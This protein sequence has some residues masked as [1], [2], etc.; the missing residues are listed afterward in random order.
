MQKLH[1]SATLPAP[2]GIQREN[3]TISY[4]KYGSG[5]I[6]LTALG[7]YILTTSGI[8]EG[9][10]RRTTEYKAAYNK[11][12]MDMLHA[13]ESDNRRYTAIHR[14]MPKVSD[15]C[16]YQKEL[17]SLAPQKYKRAQFA[18]L[19]PTKDSVE[20]DL[21]H[22]VQ[23]LNFD[24]TKPEKVSEKD[25]I[26]KN[27]NSLTERRSQSWIEAK[28][29]FEQIEEVRA[30]R[31]NAR[32]LAEY[33]AIYNKKQ[34][35]IDGTESAVK[36]VLSSL[37]TAIT[38][39]YNIGITCE[40]KRTA[41]QLNAEIIFEDGVN[42]PS[43][44]ATILASGKISIKNKLVKEMI[45]DKTNST[46]SCVYYLA[47][48][49]FN[50]SPNIQYLQMSVFDRSKQNPLMWVELERT[51]FSRIKPGLVDLC[52]DILGYPHVLDFKTKGDALE[53]AIMNVSTFDKEV[54]FA[55]ETANNSHLQSQGNVTEISGDKIAI[56]FEQ[57]Y[58]LTD[59]PDI[60]AIVRRA[61][62]V[63]EGS[64]WGYV[65]LDK[66]YKGIIEELGN[67]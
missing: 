26:H 28:E 23:S 54:K 14:D 53:L 27:L 63:A 65:T 6:S 1:I 57:A 44:K 30:E 60:S 16:T 4:P 61:I 40:Y 19:K 47:S 49:L 48:Y 41:H 34:D 37:C 43:S 11:V 35:Y 15:I 46:L 39:P 51:R 22:E 5:S 2:I 21:R 64:G 45:S 56:T 62:A 25:Y 24:K 13:Y 7:D 66:Q 10:A 50:V 3:F 17:M 32:F 52:L 59:L 33:K 9:S 38:V 58:R 67:A 36:E 29:L 55:I 42:V 8:T 18:F 12:S 31:E 20:E